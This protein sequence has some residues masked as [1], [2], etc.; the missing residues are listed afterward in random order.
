MNPSFRQIAELF[1]VV[2]L[3][4][5]ADTKALKN[6][7]Q[8]KTAKESEDLGKLRLSEG[9]YQNAIRH[10]KESI[11]QRDTE[12][13]AILVDLAGAYD[14]GDLEL[15]AFRQY[16]KALKANSESSESLLGLAD[17]LRRSGRFRDSIAELEKAIRL[18]PGNAYYH[19][20][21]A[22]ALREM[23][24]PT[25][26]LAA[27]QYAVVVQPDEPF[28]HYWIGDLLIQMKRYE[29]ALQSFRA[30]IELSPGDDHLYLRVSVAFWK[31]GRKVEAIKAIRLASDLDT[32]KVVY[33]GMLEALLRANGQQEEADMEVERAEKMDRYDTDIVRRTLAE[34]GIR[35]YDPRE[36]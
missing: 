25:K 3:E 28:Y 8:G 32:E 15:Q 35:D 10:F 4:G 20:K 16:K 12:D 7:L 2:E 33:A 11:S 24:E 34:M 21:L 29:E 14:Y 18:E 5:D 19:M 27:A 22:E 23:G 13:P 31:T 36:G 30:A 1:N 26:A 9:D 6:A 17:I